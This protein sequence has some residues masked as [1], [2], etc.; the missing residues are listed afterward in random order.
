MAEEELKLLIALGPAL[1][2]TMTTSSPEIRRVCERARQLARDMGKTS[3]LFATVWGSY[4]VRLASGDV[5]SA[6]G[7]TGELF[8]IARSHDDPGLLLQ[9]HHAA[10]PTELAFGDLRTAHEHT[11]RGI[12]PLQQRGTWPTSSTLWRS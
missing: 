3:E 9:A 1:M 4:F 10:W 7:L 6:R 2:T 5:R 12:A 8:S 11:E